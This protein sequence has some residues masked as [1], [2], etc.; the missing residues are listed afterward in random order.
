MKNKVMDVKIQLKI[1]S[2]FLLSQAS[3]SFIVIA[4]ETN[5]KASVSQASQV[6]TAIT[7]EGSEDYPSINSYLNEGDTSSVKPSFTQ[8]SG[9]GQ[10]Y[11]YSY[12]SPPYQFSSGG[13]TTGVQMQP[14]Q[15]AFQNGG[16]N[17]QSNSARRPPGQRF[18]SQQ[19][20]GSSGGQFGGGG[21]GGSTGGLKGSGFDSEI[22][23]N[24]ISLSGSGGKLGSSG[25]GA[26]GGN[27]GS[28]WA[29][30]GGKFAGGSGGFSGAGGGS[31]GFGGS[32][33][34]GGQGHGV[35][36][37]GH[38]YHYGGPPHPPHDDP[39]RAG[40]MPGGPGMPPGGF[41]PSLLYL[42][43]PGFWVPS[44][45]MYIQHPGYG[46]GQQMP[47]YGGSF[48]TS[49]QMAGSGFSPTQGFMSGQRPNA[50]TMGFGSL[51]GQRPQR[52]QQMSN[53]GI[54]VAGGKDGE[55]LGFTVPKGN[56]V[57]TQGSVHQ[58]EKTQV[59]GLTGG[60]SSSAGS[61]SEPVAIKVETKPEESKIVLSNSGTVIPNSTIVANS[62]L[63]P[64]AEQKTKETVAVPAFSSGIA[65]AT[66]R[67]GI[68]EDWNLK[69][70]KQNEQAVKVA[71]N[72]DGGKAA[73]VQQGQVGQGMA[74]SA[75][76]SNMEGGK[77][78]AGSFSLGDMSGGGQVN[79]GGAS[80]GSQI[81]LITMPVQKTPTIKIKTVGAPASSASDGLS[82]GQSGDGNMKLASMP[83]GQYFSQSGGG[84]RQMQSGG[85]SY[86]DGSYSGGTDARYSNGKMING[87]PKFQIYP[88]SFIVTPIKTK[89][90]RPNALMDENYFLEDLNGGSGK[91]TQGRGSSNSLITGGG[92]SKT[93]PK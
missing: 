37:G 77:S 42:T 67:D 81:K 78:N 27:V 57:Q 79:G 88:N 73:S 92:D 17:W 21:F 76:P 90:Q 55:A 44:T 91:S 15:W 39:F 69:V 64:S 54:S 82:F 1:I 19:G 6:N 74:V 5:G 65:G 59:V 2:H 47:G 87:R 83:K 33:G 29:D 85:G 16:L 71:L 58:P 51:F 53:S 70:P 84:V 26:F 86:S 12:G 10:S 66:E 89:L 32:L 3:A 80:R 31:P 63:V 49:G 8:F 62:Q 25:V 60:S 34:N 61:N 72:V 4:Q 50:G 68:P 7:N 13:Q 9:P 45:P 38:R 41:M 30:N 36:S 56:S 40:T 18:T 22:G 48:Q 93:F 23:G 46:Y 11:S 20:L 75:I 24:G 52:P 28:G 14:N 35:P 43:S